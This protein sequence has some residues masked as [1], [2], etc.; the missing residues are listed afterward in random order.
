MIAN[1]KID[2]SDPMAAGFLQYARTLPFATV[3]GE[4][5]SA[6][7]AWQKAIDEGA[8]TVDEFVDEMK[9]RIAKWPDNA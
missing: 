1:V 9:A 8:A 3:D 6:K 5:K 7:S 4:G 2:L